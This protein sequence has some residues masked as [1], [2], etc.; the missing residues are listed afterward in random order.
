MLSLG[1]AFIFIARRP[2][3][4]ECVILPFVHASLYIISL[5]PRRPSGAFPR[6]N[7]FSVWIFSLA[8]FRRSHTLF[9]SFSSNHSFSLSLS[10]CLSL[11]LHA[12]A[13]AFTHRHFSLILSAILSFRIS[14][15]LRRFLATILTLSLTRAIL[16]SYINRP[17]Y[18][19]TLNARVD[20]FV[21]FFFCIVCQERICVSKLWTT[22]KSFRCHASCT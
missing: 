5:T 13:H 8:N 11:I 10:L 12:P 2:K 19:L 22:H 21:F 18:L 15:S 1:P 16:L 9:L 3:Y 7:N 17:E 4:R 20:L 6:A 14:C